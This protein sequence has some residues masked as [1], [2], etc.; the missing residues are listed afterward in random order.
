MPFDTFSAEL[1]HVATACLAYC[2]TRYGGRGL[3]VDQPIHGGIAWRPTFWLKPNAAMIIGVEVSDKLYPEV[4]RGAAHDVSKFDFPVAVI[5]ACPLEVYVGDKKQVIVSQLRNHGF[6]IITVDDSGGAVSQ[7][8]CLPLA[9]H[10]SEK[11]LEDELRGLTR[12]LKVAF[13]DAHATY[14]TNVGQGLQEAGQIVEAI[15][16]ALA[17]QSV[18]AGY[19]S[20]ALKNKTP[21]GIIDELYPQTRFQNHRAALGGARKFVKKYRNTASHPAQSAKDA[22]AKIRAC[23]TGLIEAAGI[24]RDLQEMMK[25]M[26]FRLIVHLA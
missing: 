7:H 8:P 9:Q 13:R 6:G 10:V 2:K 3:T 18:R 16:I 20:A 24:A 26:K 21:A 17:S 14:R 19:A 5:L 15:I 23:R 25:K 1:K 22:I 12:T 4:L 11:E